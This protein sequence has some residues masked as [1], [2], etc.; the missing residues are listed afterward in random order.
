[1]IP[2]IS[3]IGLMETNDLGTV[4]QSLYSDDDGSLP[5]TVAVGLRVEGEATRA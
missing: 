4:L 3:Q 2:Y 1:M 5:L